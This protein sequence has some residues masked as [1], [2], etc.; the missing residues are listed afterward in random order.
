MTFDATVV[1]QT[2]ADRA[3]ADTH[4]LV[5]HRRPT[6]PRPRPRTRLR[7]AAIV[8][9]RLFRALQYEGNLIP[10]PRKHWKRIIDELRPDLLIMDGAWQTIPREWSYSAIGEQIDDQL[11]DLLGYCRHA[12]VPT[13]LWMTA[14][15]RHAMHLGPL[16]GQFDRVYVADPDCVGRLPGVQA[17]HV[18]LPAVQPALFHPY[19]PV[20]ELDVASMGTLF[21]G[22]IDLLHGCVSEQQLSPLI[23]FDL[24]IIETG[25][26]L[27]KSQIDHTPEPL[28]ACVGGCV[29]RLAEP[30]VYRSARIAVDLSNSERTPTARIW[31]AVERAAC[32][33]PAAFCGEPLGDQHR[34]LVV[35]CPDSGALIDV[36]TSLNG[37]ELYREKI[38]QQA[39]RA[40]FENHTYAQRLAR[41]C[42]DLGLAHD[43]NPW[44]RASLIAPTIRPHLIPRILEQFRSQTYPN[45]ELIIV[46][47]S[48][49]C[50]VNALSTNIPDKDVRVI[51][52]AKDYHAGTCLNAGNHLA[53][54]EYTFRM[55]D[56]DHYGPNYLLDTMLAFRAVDAAVSGKQ[57]TLMTFDEENTVFRRRNRS[58][59]PISFRG[60]EFA[61]PRV[62]L[63][64]CSIGGKRAF[65]LQHPYPDDSSGA[66]DTELLLNL[67]DL[68]P[69]T[70]C[71]QLDCLNL[72]VQ[73]N[74]DPGEHT[75]VVDHSVLRR[76]ATAFALT[77]DECMA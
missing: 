9:P 52:V 26:R 76:G 25:M 65:F 77:V 12:G 23:E 67:R 43:W 15:W 41:I 6:M 38:A 63:A 47:N 44:P 74:R 73:R 48:N 2:I 1:R 66:V 19:T 29:H 17:E 33:L 55:D 22:W 34:Q 27:R 16:S 40:A 62:A 68:W 46:V 56:D 18:L 5:P 58:L 21:D 35:P 70:I 28:R 7:I 75:W 36:I 61:D 57:F 37:D 8:G 69:D 42:E 45:R 10:L 39:W 59:R 31:R 20:G 60:A 71:V 13:V 4:Y 54:G 53:T 11:A 64:G 24:S 49:D 30:T 32:R 14:D 50:D 51:R 3:L 72:V